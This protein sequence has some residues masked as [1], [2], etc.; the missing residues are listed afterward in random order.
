MKRVAG[1]LLIVAVVL[2]APTAAPA[3]TGVTITLS[4]SSNTITFGEHVTLSGS[5]TG[6]PA[7]STVEVRNGVGSSIASATTDAA[8][9][10]STRIEPSGSD[11]YVAVL[12]DGVSEP[13]TV[14]VRA[15]VSARMGPVRLF[16]HV[17]VRGT[18]DPARPG[19]SVVF[20]LI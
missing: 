19:S 8:G 16:D 3:Q 15:V 18:V 2:L 20:E 9:A 4:A 13:V 5:S 6:A 14:G 11:S 7:G 17:V 1:L 10:F 12:G